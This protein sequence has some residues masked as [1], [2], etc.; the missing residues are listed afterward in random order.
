M[1]DLSFQITG[2][3]AAERGLTPLLHFTLEVHNTPPD[4]AIHAVMLQ[5]QIQ[6]ES[7]RRRY[8]GREQEQLFE[9]FGPAQQWGQTLRTRLWTHAFTNVPR[10]T[11]STEVVLP[12]TCTYDLNVAATKYFYALEEGDVPLL[13]LFSGTIFYAAEAGRMQVQQVSWSKEC[14]YRMPVAVWQ[15]MMDRHYPNSAWLALPRDV[16]DRL[17]AYRRRHGLPTWEQTIEHL[18]PPVTEPLGVAGN[19]EV[20]P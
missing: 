8:N 5:A 16:F 20:Q 4:Q 17:Y 1:P 14:T 11:G 7:T 9:L 2:V 15:E 12:V 19:G 18:L 10:F 3:E 13:F 6:V